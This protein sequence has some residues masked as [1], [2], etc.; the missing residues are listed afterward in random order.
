MCAL[1]TK[2]SRIDALRRAATATHCD[3]EEMMGGV[4]LLEE[5]S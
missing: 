4:F 3:C 5:L 1:M 2:H